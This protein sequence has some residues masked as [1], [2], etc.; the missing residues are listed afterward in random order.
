MITPNT[1]YG[2]ATNL[3]VAQI[4]PQILTI[5]GLFLFLIVVIALRGLIPILP[6]HVQRRLGQPHPAVETT[7]EISAH[8]DAVSAVRFEAVSILR[9]EE[10]RLLPVLED[11]VARLNRGHRVLIQMSLAEMVRPEE[12]SGT[13]LQRRAAAAAI[14][15]RR[16]DFA[17]ID[18]T[19]RLVL[20]IAYH[21]TGH[22]ISEAYMREAVTREAVHQA[23]IAYLEVAQGFNED[24]LFRRVYG[25]LAQAGADTA[26]A[27]RK[28][29]RLVSG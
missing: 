18:R 28:P 10:A 17:V 3:D 20:A 12:A 26:D 23:G 29:V 19:G 14:T 4:D 8:M 2:Q 21:G 11:A 25:L 1:H 24:D 7:L 27:A 5:A 16:L 13:L 6:A 9:R 15:T 22:Y